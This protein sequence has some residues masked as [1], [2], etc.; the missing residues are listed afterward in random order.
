MY[1]LSFNIN[2]GKYRFGLTSCCKDMHLRL[3]KYEARD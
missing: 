3:L 2:K 1:E